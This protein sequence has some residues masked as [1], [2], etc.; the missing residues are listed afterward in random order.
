MLCFFCH[1]SQGIF[2]ISLVIF[3]F[4]LAVILGAFTF[5]IFVNLPN[6]LWLLISNLI[7]LWFKNIVFVISVSPSKFIEACVV[8][9]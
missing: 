7:P 4:K 1:L 9:A 3:F 5:H 8:T 2:L 6:F